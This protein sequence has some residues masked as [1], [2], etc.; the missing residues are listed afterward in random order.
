MPIEQ[1]IQTDTQFQSLT[2]GLPD[3]DQHK[4]VACIHDDKTGLHCLIA[5][6][7]TSRGPGVGGCRLWQYD[8]LSDALT[9]V[10]RLS[11]GMTYKN[12]MADLAFG[13]GKAVI[14]APD[15]SKYS[16]SDVFA[17]F[18][19]A[20]EVLNGDYCTA[21]D[22]GTSPE[23]MANIHKNSKHIFG[24]AD[25]SGDPSPFTAYGVFLGIKEA[26]QFRLQTDSLKGVHVAV[27][28]LGH[29]GHHLCELLHEAGARLT[30][31][32]VR[33]DSIKRV[34]DAFQAKTCAPDDIYSIAAD[35]YAPCA[36]G[37]TV[38]PQTLEKLQVSVIA[39]AAN[40]QLST[41]SIANELKQRQVLYVPDYVI[42]A[43]G[44]VNIACESGSDYDADRAR[45]EVDKISP[46]LREIF[47][48]SEKQDRCTIA[49]ANDIAQKKF[50]PNTESNIRIHNL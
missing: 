24:L 37:A 46:R 43:G 21:E 11:Q 45:Q 44:I 42:N 30:V 31:T 32:D 9:D 25:K 17:S 8:E 15:F 39:G 48:Q 41:E 3:F 36:L 19:R 50:S 29:V 38:N 49:V 40:N 12:A 35:V 16:R 20:L 7:N 6:H 34:K 18:G 13:G 33:Q 47:E 22:V 5:V 2:Q 27:Q 4:H 14:L 28:G 23:D 26:V 10:L 1:S